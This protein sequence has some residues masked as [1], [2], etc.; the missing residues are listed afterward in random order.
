ML[1]TTDTPLTHKRGDSFNRIFYIP[2]YIPDGFFGG[3][4]VHSQMRTPGGE[5]VADMGH[6]W[7]GDKYRFVRLFCADTRDW[8]ITAIHGDVQFTRRGD[9]FV[10][11]S[12]TQQFNI[13]RDQTIPTEA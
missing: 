11:S 4:E 13:V 10:I 12:K 3:F 1:L 9:G 8:P 2:L 7:I 5:L 6:Q